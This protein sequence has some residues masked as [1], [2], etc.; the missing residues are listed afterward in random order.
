M[1]RTI[2]GE[3][4]RE[5]KDGS[6][7]THRESC[8]YNLVRLHT[9]HERECELLIERQETLARDFFNAR[10]SGQHEA[11]VTFSA[12][13]GK[14]DSEDAL[15]FGFADFRR[16]YTA[17]STFYTHGLPS[18][19]RRFVTSAKS[20]EIKEIEIVEERILLERGN[21]NHLEQAIFECV[22]KSPHDALTKLKFLASL[23]LDGGDMEQDYFAYLVE[24]CVSALESETYFSNP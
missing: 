14:S 24:E 13:E 5:T 8:V 22:P 18:A 1:D 17:A 4:V 16:R 7:M 6:E 15:N 2:D 19:K 9:F 12:P 3:L 20:S 23:M 11:S 21:M 10:A